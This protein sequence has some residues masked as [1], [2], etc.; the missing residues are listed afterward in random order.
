VNITYYKNLFKYRLNDSFINI[1]RISDIK[2]ADRWSALVSLWRNKKWETTVVRMNRKIAVMMK[3]MT[4]AQMEVMIAA[5]RKAKMIAAVKMIAVQ[6]R[7][8]WQESLWIL[9]MKH[10][11][12]L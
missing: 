2:K 11:K 8:A 5:A 3:M 9:L 1:Y 4:A 12:T 10:G 6:V 7:R